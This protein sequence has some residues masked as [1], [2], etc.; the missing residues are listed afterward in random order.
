LNVRRKHAPPRRKFNPFPACASF[1][2]EA[3]RRP[4]DLDGRSDM[5]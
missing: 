1:R 5:S 2:A 4:I 3:K